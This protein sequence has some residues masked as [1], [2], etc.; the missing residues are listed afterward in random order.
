[1]AHR[2]GLD[3]AGPVGSI[4]PAPLRPRGGGHGFTANESIAPLSTPHFFRTCS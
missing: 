2:H 1:M 4:G 3:P